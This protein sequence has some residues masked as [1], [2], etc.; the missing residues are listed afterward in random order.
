M[1]KIPAQGEYDLKF[2]I[3]DFDLKWPIGRTVIEVHHFAELS[4]RLTIA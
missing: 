2:A 3:F 1:I 4:K